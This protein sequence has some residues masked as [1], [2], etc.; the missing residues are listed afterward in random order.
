MKSP[1]SP[2]HKGPPEGVVL[3]SRHPNSCSCTSLHCR[4]AGVLAAVCPWQRVLERWNSIYGTFVR[5][6]PLAALGGEVAAKEQS[7]AQHGNCT[8]NSRG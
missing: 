8:P 2:V 3:A 1:H 6:A 7:S 4:C 5:Q